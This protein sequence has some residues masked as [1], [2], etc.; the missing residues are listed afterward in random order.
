M[1]TEGQIYSISKRLYDAA[2]LCDPGA[3]AA[4]D[5]VDV[6]Q[7]LAAIRSDIEGQDD[8]QFFQV[9]NARPESRV[10]RQISHVPE[11]RT[12]AWL[13]PLDWVRD[14]DQRI[15]TPKGGPLVR[16]D[17]LCWC[18][19]D[20]MHDVFGSLAMW[21]VRRCTSMLRRAIAA[22]TSQ[23]SLA[24]PLLPEIC[25]AR[26]ASDSLVVLDETP[27]PGMRWHHVLGSLVAAGAFA[28]SGGFVNFSSI[29]GLSIEDVKTMEDTGMLVSKWSEFGELMVATKVEAIHQQLQFVCHLGTLVVDLVPRTSAAWQ[30]ASKLEIAIAL[31]QLGW[32]WSVAIGCALGAATHRSFKPISSPK[33]RPEGQ[34]LV[35]FRVRS[36]FGAIVAYNRNPPYSEPTP[37]TFIVDIL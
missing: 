26:S 17:L 30:A 4:F 5:F 35:Q 22:P 1:L 7:S 32:T 27:A 6:L 31:L 13:S 21:K 3:G 12:V 8:L 19:A 24:R 29:D 14:G 18:T 10:S 15:L 2:L 23:P 34:K 9:V 36:L 33:L 11:S 16:I 25:D 37:S 20:V 28:G